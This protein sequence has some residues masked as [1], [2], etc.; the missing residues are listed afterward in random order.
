MDSKQDVDSLFGGAEQAHDEA[1]WAAIVAQYR[2]LLITW[3]VQCPATATS[4]ESP[5]AIADQALT[6]AWLA[7]APKGFAAF[8]NLAALLAY[9]RVCVTHTAIDATRASAAQARATQWLTVP[10]ASDPEQTLLEQLDRT[11]FWH[12]VSRLIT[13]EQERVVLVERYVLDLP[14]RIILAR[15]PTLFADITAIYSVVR[16]LCCRLARHPELRQLWEDAVAV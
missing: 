2:R 8:P 10:E 16:N 4:G 1:A 15:H 12:L 11:E 5:E 6:R 13:T 3:A 7:I 9:L 14:P